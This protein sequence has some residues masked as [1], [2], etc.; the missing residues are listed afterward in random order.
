MPGKASFGP[1]KNDPSQFLF[2]G[3]RADGKIFM[4]YLAVT[5][6]LREKL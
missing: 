5:S 3:L 1:S 6:R 4:M 2:H